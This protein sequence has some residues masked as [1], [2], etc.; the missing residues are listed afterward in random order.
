M[1][2]TRK[3]K[4]P[5]Y[6]HYFAWVDDPKSLLSN[7]GLKNAIA[8]A[9][10]DEV[11]R[12]LE[13]VL[14]WSEQ[15]NVAVKDI[16]KDVPPFPYIRESLEKMQPVADLIVVSG[17]PGEA[18]AREWEEHDIAKYVEV[19]AGQ[20]MGTKTQHL[21]YTTKGKY[22]KNHV[23]MIG[24]APGDMKAAKANDALFYPINPGAETESWERFHDEA[25]NKFVNGEYAGDYEQKVIAEFDACL[26]ELPPWG[27]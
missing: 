3:F 18:L 11:K 8:A 22:E 23:I 1:V 25:F 14:K 7:D 24:D 15:V 26:P 4:V 5:Q 21:S 13:H 10:N 9:T 2:K 12:E 17:T 6:P 27:K 20:E 19:I 16:V